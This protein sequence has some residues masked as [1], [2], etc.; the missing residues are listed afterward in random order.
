MLFVWLVQKKGWGTVF[1]LFF[2]SLVVRTNIIKCLDFVVMAVHLNYIFHVVCR[3]VCFSA[4][5]FFF[6]VRWLGWFS[7][8]LFF[9]ERSLL[10][11]YR[12]ARKDGASGCKTVVF[13]YVACTLFWLWFR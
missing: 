2:L 5:R 9:N 1:F 10:E 8:S 11:N 7:F 3:N 13:A 4:M 12:A 6:L